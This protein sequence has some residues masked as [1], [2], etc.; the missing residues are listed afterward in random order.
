MAKT[1]L[2]AQE[3]ASAADVISATQPDPEE[4][5]GIYRHLHDGLLYELAKLDE[6]KSDPQKKT[7]RLRVPPQKNKE[8]GAVTHPGLY[9][10]GTKEQFKSHFERP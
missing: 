9:W 2:S 1:D 10:E 4:Y 8:S 6:D 7:H 3:I 5:R